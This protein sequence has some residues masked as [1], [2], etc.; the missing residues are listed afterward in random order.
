[1]IQHPPICDPAPFVRAAAAGGI[2]GVLE[3]AGMDTASV[4]G[5]FGLSVEDAHDPY[6]SMSLCAFTELL[7]QAAE[8]TATPHLGMK[9]GYELD[10]ANWGPFGFVVMNAPTVWACFQALEQ[11]LPPWQSGT[12]VQAVREAGQAR[13]EY[14]ILDPKVRFRDQD[15]ELSL[16]VSLNHVRRA[17]RGRARPVAI[18]FV[19]NP[20]APRAAYERYLGLWPVF[21]SET[22]ALWYDEADL[23]LPN[24]AADI[25]LYNVVR[26]HLQ[27]LVTEHAAPRTLVRIVE[28]QIRAHLCGDAP[29]METVA[30]R[31]SLEP[32]TLQRRLADEGTSYSDLVEAVRRS[33]AMRLLESTDTAIKQ[34]AYL[35]GYSDPSAF[36]KSFR[37]WSEVT[38]GVYRKARAGGAA[39]A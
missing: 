15:A 13:I 8:L 1:M 10:P 34:I 4:L 28:D 5:R 19:H 37:R 38:P 25:R 31:L 3:H 16:A 27:D 36:I 39:S 7:H 29:G 11:F 33:E 21:E 22:N 12:Y 14:E 18:S 20:I 30:A 9:I 35:L 26:R 2:A 24:E 23:D 17:T 32:R 6:A